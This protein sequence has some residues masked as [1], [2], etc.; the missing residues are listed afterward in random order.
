MLGAHTLSS[1]ASGL[2]S[3]F[4]HDIIALSSTCAHAQAHRGICV[5]AQTIYWD[6]H[7]T[8]EGTALNMAP[9][10]ME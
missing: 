4:L 5:N 9:M 10:A 8:K 7:G 6:S 2:A 3:F 1:V